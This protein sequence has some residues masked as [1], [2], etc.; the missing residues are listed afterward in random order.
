ML[1]IIVWYCFIIIFGLCLDFMVLASASALALKLWRRP[2]S[3]G[4]SLGLEVLASVNITG[5]NWEWGVTM[6]YHGV[7]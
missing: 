6:V 7:P 4:L 5:S 2:R 1:L 3:F